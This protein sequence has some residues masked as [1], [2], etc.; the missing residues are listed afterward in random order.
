MSTTKIRGLVAST[1]LLLILG[2]LV[3]TQLW[4]IYLDSPRWFWIFVVLVSAAFLAY[5]AVCGSRWMAKCRLMSMLISEAI[6]KGV[7]RV[8]IRLESSQELS[9][10]GDDAEIMS[11]QTGENI[12]IVMILPDVAVRRIKE[13]FGDMTLCYVAEV[14]FPRYEYDPVKLSVGCPDIDLQT[15]KLMHT[16]LVSNGLMPDST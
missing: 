1:V 7:L 4:G 6:D 3:G 16:V 2:C 10:P 11:V 9:F 5:L 8:P 14:L 12:A 15:A 13:I